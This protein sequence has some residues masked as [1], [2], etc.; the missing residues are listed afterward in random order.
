MDYAQKVHKFEAGLPSI[1]G[2]NNFM[3]SE[4]SRNSKEI[5]DY[6][7]HFMK[8]EGKVEV[9][10]KVLEL[11][12]VESLPKLGHEYKS[13][14]GVDVIPCKSDHVKDTISKVLAGIIESGV[15]LNDIAILV[16]KRQDKEKM[17]VTINEITENMGIKENITMDTVKSF[18]GLD[19]P[20]V[21][22]INPHCNEEHADF[23][24]FVLSLATRARDNLVII[25]SSEIAQKKLK[26]D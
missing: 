14:K 26:V 8:P 6:A 19:K 10:D 23:N 11:K 25:S 5:F 20:T 15:D 12:R 21:I 13:G 2:K 22:G 9:K 3:L 7:M 16:G 1:V 18:S 17:G 24:K 4:I